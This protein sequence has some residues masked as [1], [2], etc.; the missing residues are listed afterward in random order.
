MPHYFFH[1]RNTTVDF[2]DEDGAELPS[3]AGARSHAIE[4]IRCLIAAEARTGM[5]D[6]R[7]HIDIADESGAII[8]SVP[9]ADA[10]ELHL[11]G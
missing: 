4:G 1:I 2:A 11:S 9:H 6:F 5:I 8:M 7:G 10:F 3:R